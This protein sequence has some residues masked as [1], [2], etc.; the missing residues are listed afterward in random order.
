MTMIRRLWNRVFGSPDPEKP[1]AEPDP[2]E[3]EDLSFEA[4]LKRH[5]PALT[6]AHLEV[7]RKLLMAA[8]GIQS[9]ME[10]D[11]TASAREWGDFVDQVV[12]RSPRFPG[13][14]HQ[15]LMYYAS[16]MRSGFGP[17]GGSTNG[18]WGVADMCEVLERELNNA[19]VTLRDW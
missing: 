13:R 10:A 2:K 7:L 9:D 14:L 11:L 4:E 3:A 19:G 16:S 12:R 17:R 1:E 15:D 8:Q 6:P 5:M 18:A